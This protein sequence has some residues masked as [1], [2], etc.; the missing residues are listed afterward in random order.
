M[1]CLYTSFAFLF[2]V[3]VYNIHGRVLSKQYFFYDGT[4][5]YFGPEHLPFAILAIAAVLVFNIF[6]LLLLIL[7]PC[8]ISA[9]RDA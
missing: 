7:Y 8:Q 6:P 1:K 2:P 4:V 3:N 9:F 5:E